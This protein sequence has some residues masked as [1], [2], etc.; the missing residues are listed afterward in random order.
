LVS[1]A[2]Q[3]ADELGDIYVWTDEVEA[4]F[5]DRW[6]LSFEDD[7]LDEDLPWD[8]DCPEN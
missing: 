3:I 8:D 2:N 6:E 7:D 1:F 5:A 4:L